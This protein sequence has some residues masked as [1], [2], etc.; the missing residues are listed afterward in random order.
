MGGICSKGAAVDKSPSEITLSAIDP[1]DDDMIGYESQGKKKSNLK[2]A[3]VAE[4]KEKGLHEQPY[5]VPKEPQDPKETQLSRVLSQ[6]SKSTKS[7]PAS[8]GKIAT[9]KVSEA[10]SLWGRA[11]TAGLGK[12]V[13][14]LD[15]LGSSMTS[16]KPSGGFVS[17]VATKGN[18]ISILAFE[19]A[20][21]IV[22][23]ANLMQS[24]S[25]ENIE[26]LKNAVLRSEGVHNLISKDMDELL[27]IAAADKREELRVFSREIVRFGNRCK[28]PQWHNLDRYFAKQESEFTPQEQ[29]KE[30]SAGAMQNLMTLV[31]YTAELYHELHALD[32]FEQDYRRKHQEEENLTAA[33]RGDNLQ[34]L[35]QELKSQRKHVKSLKKKSLW[36]QILEEVMEKL[37]DIVHFL[38][39]QI[40]DAFGITDGDKPV[41]DS[42][43][44]H[45]SLGSAGLALHYANIITQID[46]LVSRSGS[47]PPNTRDALYHALPPSIKSAL[48]A[49]LQSFPV[50]EELTVNEI[51]TE[52]EKTLQWLVPHANNTIRAHHGFGWVGEWANMGTEL[53]SQQAGQTN[54]IK[55]ETLHH[56]DKNKT[57]AC[58]LELVVW[59][60]HLISQIRSSNGCIKSPS[61]SPIRS[62]TKKPLAQNQAVAPASMLTRE[63]QEMLRCVDFRKLTPGISKS[64]EFDAAGS[65]L[66]KDDRLSKSSNHSPTSESTKELS[67][68]RKSS[69]ASIINFDIDRIKVLDVID[70]VENL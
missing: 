54:L 30:T 57:E 70:R 27:G 48:C 32:R 49:K 45:Q 36:S 44:S 28:D 31:R 55:I 5:S 3:A 62:P 46:T 11:G 37:V 10:S 38:H 26:Y 9:A 1:R 24:L 2:T 29:L 20:N 58:I 4:T 33:Q 43:S 22:K 66:S 63:D 21:T 67:S 35:R 56:A 60:H 34:I 12:A 40:H 13:E 64:Q 68:L 47:V 53:N 41:R 61:K 17:A 18:K 6:K 8:S 52:M 42:T 7:K 23:G 69:V 16:L 50:R 25:N 19:V 39:L 51:K 15:T 14:V 65:R 59:L